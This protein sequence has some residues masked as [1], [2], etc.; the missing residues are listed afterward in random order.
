MRRS[1]ALVLVSGAVAAAACTSS[2]AARPAP[3][4]A[5]ASL[6]P[7]YGGDVLHAFADAGLPTGNAR[8][9]TAGCTDYCA[10]RVTS[11]AVTVTVARDVPTAVRLASVDGFRAGRVVLGY[12][13][14][15]TPAALRPRYQAQLEAYCTGH[16][17]S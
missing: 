11:D 6:A 17:C 8:E 15:R 9:T 12:A 1:L 4:A 16:P 10:Q 5:P 14:A 7:V 2:P 13:A 3:S